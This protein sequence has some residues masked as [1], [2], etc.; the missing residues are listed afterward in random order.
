MVYLA[1]LH[2][3]IIMFGTK[4]SKYELPKIKWSRNVL[5]AASRDYAEN[6]MPHLRLHGNVTVGPTGVEGITRA[7]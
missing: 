6:V 5:F 4:L 7:H 2:V 1:E 3:R